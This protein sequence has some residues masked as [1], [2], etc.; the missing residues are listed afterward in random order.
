MS[1][2]PTTSTHYNTIVN[3]RLQKL[4]LEWAIYDANKDRAEKQK[5]V[6]HKEIYFLVEKYNV[7]PIDIASRIRRKKQHV[8]VI[9]N[10]EKGGAR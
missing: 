7:R 3:N 4:E 6:L 9:L 8:N 10:Y 1:K 5:E 2:Q